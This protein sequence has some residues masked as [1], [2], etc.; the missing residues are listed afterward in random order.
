[1]FCTFI[2]PVPGYVCTYLNF[3]W[4][5]YLLLFQT[6]CRLSTCWLKSFLVQIK[7]CVAEWVFLSFLSFLEPD[8]YRAFN[9]REAYFKNISQGVGNLGRFTSLKLVS[10]VY[11]SI[12]LLDSPCRGCSCKDPAPCPFSSPSCLSLG[13]SRGAEWSKRNDWKLKLKTGHRGLVVGGCREQGQGAGKEEEE[14]L[15]RK[16]VLITGACLG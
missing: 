14:D 6:L 10:A 12:Y 5:Q 16:F 1:M 4:T 9:E 15:G 2:L 8:T 3:W 11:K 7:A 13:I